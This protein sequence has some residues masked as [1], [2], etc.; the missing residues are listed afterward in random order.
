MDSLKQLLQEQYQLQAQT[1]SP[2]KGGWAALA[3]RVETKKHTYFLKMYEKSRTSTPKWTALIDEYVPALIWLNEQNDLNG[4]V[5]VPILTKN[6]QCKCENDKGI[7]LLYEHIEGETIGPQQLTNDQVEQLATII[8]ALHAIG[9]E[10]APIAT[11]QLKEDF[12]L[13]FAVS[14][15]K[16]LTEQLATLPDDIQTTIAPFS[17]PLLSL[18]ESTEKRANTLKQRPL[19]YALCHTDLHHWN[20]MTSQG[21]L[22][23]IDWEGLKLAPVEADMMFVVDE[24]YNNAFMDH[25]RKRHLDYVIDQECLAFYQGRRKLEDIWEFLEQLLFDEQKPTERAAIL[26]GL[27]KELEAVAKACL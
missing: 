18:I 25:Y 4:K 5:P 24:C 9:E 2:Q 15:Y 11:A 20:L 1:I 14:L 12:S 26:E 16:L 10:T 19:R 13:P 17:Q 8:A 21:E 22:V 3:Y 27:E 6:G 7:F 23:L